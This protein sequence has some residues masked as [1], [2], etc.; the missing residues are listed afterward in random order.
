[1][2]Q[3]QHCVHVL[4]FWPLPGETFACCSAF[5]ETVEDIDIDKGV[6]AKVVE[7]GS[8]PAC[9]KFQAGKSVCLNNKD[10]FDLP[11][12]RREGEKALLDKLKKTYL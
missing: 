4:F 11:P 9:P 3:C 10:P 7:Y 2:K 8:G 1:M 6:S 12:I 5:G